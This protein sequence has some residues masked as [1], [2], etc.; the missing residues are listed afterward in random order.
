MLCRYWWFELRS[1]QVTCG[2]WFDRVRTTSNSH[3][4]LTWRPCQASWLTH[5]HVLS[6]WLQ[7]A[8]YDLIWLYLMPVRGSQLTLLVFLI[9]VRGRAHGLVGTAN[10]ASHTWWIE[11]VLVQYVLSI[12]SGTIFHHVVLT[13]QPYRASWFNHGLGFPL[14]L[15]SAGH[16]TTL[17]PVTWG[18]STVWSSWT[19]HQYQFS[20]M[21][22]LFD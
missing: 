20:S 21:V 10:I 16:M 1:I 15:Q 18:R 14:W 5:G 3:A 4:V 17:M 13:E 12:I 8:A 6:L 9:W 2:L 19:R 11:S 22:C 7:P